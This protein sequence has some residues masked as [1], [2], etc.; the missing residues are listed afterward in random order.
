MILK[1]L[2]T[3]KILFRELSSHFRNKFIFNAKLFKKIY[4]S[5]F[6]YANIILAFGNSFMSITY[7][8]HFAVVDTQLF[9]RGY[10][11]IKYYL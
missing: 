6:F 10:Y 3:E 4:N 5:S 9:R 1:Q 11:P 2:V 8:I 7:Y